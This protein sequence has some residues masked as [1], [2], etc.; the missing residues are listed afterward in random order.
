[1]PSIDRRDMLKGVAAAAAGALIPQAALAAPVPQAKVGVRRSGER[2]RARYSWLD[3]RFTFSFSR[4]QDKRWMGFRSLRVINEDWI[5]AGKGFPMHPHEDMEIITYVL[6]GALEHKDSMGNG[7]V[8]V[9]GQVQ[10]MSAGKGIRHSEFEPSKKK[11]VHLLQIW[12]QPDRR[13]VKP[14]YGQVKVEKK[15]LANRL[16]LV[17]S[18]SGKDGSIKI[19]QDANLHAGRLD[20]KKRLTWR[21]P[22]GRHVWIQ[23]AR[24]DLKLQGR[25]LGQGDGA[26][27]SDAGDLVLEGGNAQAELLLFDLA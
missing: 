26:W 17:A 14:G 18:K 21:N 8:I 7:A 5:S 9:P 11:A 16:Q 12:I 10:H 20:P 2:G 22:Q 1:M 15:D 24:G 3:T 27:T 19:H 25:A 23:V 4:Y 13:G 6:E